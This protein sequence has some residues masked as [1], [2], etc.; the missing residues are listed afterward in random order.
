MF[1]VDLTSAEGM[2][3][4]LMIAVL[5]II[6]GKEFKKSAIPAIGLGIFLVSI[7]LHTYQ[8]VTIT[9]QIYKAIATKSLAIDAIMIFLT[10]IAY[11]WVDD[12]EVKEK[13]RKS[14][15]NSLDWF[16]KKV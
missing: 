6:L 14:I 11:L 7:L 3:M 16:W 13:N 9:D 8:S 15:D 10:Y 12:I 5:T 1:I 4:A 2:L